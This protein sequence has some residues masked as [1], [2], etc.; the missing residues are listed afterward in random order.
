MKAL[1]NDELWPLLTLLIL[2]LIIGIKPELVLNI[3]NES[4][5]HIIYSITDKT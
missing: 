5:N 2:V 4:T 1:R 3:I